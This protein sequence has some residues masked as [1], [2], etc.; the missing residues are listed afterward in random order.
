MA[1]IEVRLRNQ[2]RDSQRKSGEYFECLT[3]IATQLVGMN[4]GQ[5][6]TAE[7]SIANILSQFNSVQYLEN[8]D[9]AWK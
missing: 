2:L 1:S 6:T 3:Q 9:I 5:L 7:R 8:G 4:L